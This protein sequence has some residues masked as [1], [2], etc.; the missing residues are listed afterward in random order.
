MDYLK[1]LIARTAEVNLKKQVIL[2]HTQR[3][4]V[5]PAS[6][7]TEEKKKLKSSDRK[8]KGLK[9]NEKTSKEVSDDGHTDYLS[10]SICV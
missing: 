7:E 1:S 9:S 8:T 3:T 10:S 6:R 5:G 4:G 2:S